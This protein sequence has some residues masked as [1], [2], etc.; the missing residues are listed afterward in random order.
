RCSSGEESLPAASQETQDA[1]AGD[2]GH[3]FFGFMALGVQ[4][5]G[6]SERVASGAG[7]A[8]GGLAA[9]EFKPQKKMAGIPFEGLL[10]EFERQ[11]EL[12]VKRTNASG[13][14]GSEP[15]PGSQ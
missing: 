14:P 9:A 2:I 13:Q 11:G 6:L 7:E 8:K 5:L 1:G 4:L 10:K 15:V 3:G 12:L